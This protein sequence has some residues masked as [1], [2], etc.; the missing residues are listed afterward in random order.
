MN[1][2]RNVKVVNFSN[3]EGGLS[4]FDVQPKSESPLVHTRFKL[5]HFIR[6]YIKDL[7]QSKDKGM[8]EEYGLTCYTGKQ[9]SGKSLSL[10]EYLYRM[11]RKY[12]KVMIV[13]NFDYTEQDK[14]F[15]HW[16]DLINI[17]NGTDGVIFAIDEIQNEF[18]SNSWKD[19]PPF[20]LSEITQQRKQR[21]KIVASSQVFT[22]VVKQLREQ[23]YEV[24]ECQCIAK[25]WIF[26]RA[27][28]GQ[29]YSDYTDSVS[30]PPSLRRIWRRSFVQT[31]SIRQ[32][33]DSYK[34]IERIKRGEYERKV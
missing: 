24:V 19:F 32:L 34:K 14:S 2:N 33:F 12:P 29:D 23:C 27:F 16:S 15:E 21:I 13:T 28:D 3:D 25:R 17:R 7:I 10:V 11:K 18:D 9:G 8:F 20:I 5:Y 31:D 1:E 30:K 26:Q 6:Y 22:R 4:F